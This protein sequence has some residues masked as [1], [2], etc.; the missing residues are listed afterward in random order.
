MKLE[1]FCT[2]P[3]SEQLETINNCNSSSPLYI[4]RLHE[5]LN[6]KPESIFFLGNEIAEI[7]KRLKQ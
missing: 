4:E 7:Y 6:G 5:A 3:E 2:L 1:Q